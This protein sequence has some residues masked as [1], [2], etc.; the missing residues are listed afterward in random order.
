MSA[1]SWR[2]WT[3]HGTSETTT[4]G[5]QRLNVADREVPVF[6]DW[7]CLYQKKDGDITPL[8]LDSFKRGL[9]SVN[10]LYGHVRTLSEGH[11]PPEVVLTAR[12]WLTVF[13]VLRFHAHQGAKRMQRRMILRLLDPDAPQLTFM[14]HPWL[15]DWS[16][17]V[18][19][20]SC[21]RVDASRLFLDDLLRSSQKKKRREG[22]GAHSTSTT[23]RGIPGDRGL[24][25]PADVIGLSTRPRVVGS[26]TC[27]GGDESS[28]YGFRAFA[29]GTVVKVHSGGDTVSTTK[30]HEHHQAL[31]FVGPL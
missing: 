5:V 14:C 11:F 26:R 3:C 16:P 21:L 2:V 9:L 29:E 10:V 22:A 19:F 8:P 18:I 30:L 12:A 28:D 13:R 4:Q 1:S 23:V 7:S 6:W 25:E 20:S 27:P 15:C 31:R 17:L 24:S